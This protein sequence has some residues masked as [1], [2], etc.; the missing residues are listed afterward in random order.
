MI[1]LTAHGTSVKVVALQTFPMGF[2]LKEFADDKDPISVQ[3]DEVGGVEMLYDGTLYPFT[4]ANALRVAISVIPGSNEDINLKIL[5]AARRMRKKIDIIPDVTSIVISYPAG[6]DVVFSNG[7]IMTGPPADSIAGGRR[8]GNTYTFAFGA[9]NGLQSR[10]QI[11]SG[12]I[13]S[14]LDFI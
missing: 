5:L 10:T 12:V 1:D 7:T 8:R 14:I 6:G 3:D 13:Q 9:V 11:A 4:R 2:S